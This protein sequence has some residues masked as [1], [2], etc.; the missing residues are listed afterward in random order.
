[1]PTLSGNPEQAAADALF[2]AIETD[3]KTAFYSLIVGGAKA[4]LGDYDVERV[5]NMQ[6]SGAAAGGRSDKPAL[7][8]GQAQPGPPSVTF[9]GAYPLHRAVLSGHVDFVQTLLD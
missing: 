8:S 2:A 1:M 7:G 6:S 4:Q 3:D 5:V 9:G